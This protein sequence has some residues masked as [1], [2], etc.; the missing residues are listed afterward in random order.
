MNIII[1]HSNMDLDCLGSMILAKRLYPD[2]RLV[3]SRL[4][5][6][7]ARNLYNLYQNHFDF[8]NPKDLEGQS[9]EKVLIVDTCS[10]ERVKEYFAY[11]SDSNPEIEIFDHHP[12]DN[13]NIQGA[14]LHAG[15][16][17]ANT[18]ALGLK[19]RDQGIALKPEEA[20]IALTGIYADTGRFIYENVTREDFEI[21]SFLLDQGAS[22]KLV[23]TFLTTLKEDHQKDL[24]HVLMNR[25]KLRDVQGHSVLLSYLEL[26]ENAQG[27]AAVVEKIMEI[28]NPDAY[29]AVFFIKKNNTALIIARSQK[30]RIDLHNIMYA[31]GGG[32]HLKA[33]SAK[34]QAEEGEAF[35]GEF[36]QTLERALTP[37]LRAR[38][39]MTT[40][41][42]TINQK[43]SL[44]DASRYLEEVEHT[45]LPVVDDDGRAVGFLT[46]L[47]I[48]KGRKAMQMHAPVKGYMSR[49]LVSAV[50][51]TTIREIERIFYVNHIGHLPI[52]EEGIIV[53]IVTRWDYLQFKRRK[54][55][56]VAEVG[57]AG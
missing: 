40:G 30:D 8:L 32:G 34:V 12:S 44:L 11:L 2:Y 10:W 17:G 14:K 21:S 24:L 49:K 5:H 57:K 35:Y 26:A 37:A 53:G 16:Y 13:C 51:E 56:E 1:G 25:V 41:V 54:K 3:K 27:L 28:E 7:V 38:D 45:G 39:I 46:L 36:L 55:G 19:I 33:A 42:F 15:L 4:I 20:T 52:L 29:F 18:T 22:L 50:P 9:I 48:M 31:Y 6:P 43:I 23:K 47:D